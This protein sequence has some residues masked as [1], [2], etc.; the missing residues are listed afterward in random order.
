MHLEHTGFHEIEVIEKVKILVEQALTG[1]VDVLQ[2]AIPATPEWRD[3]LVGGVVDGEMHWHVVYVVITQ[4]KRHQAD[5]IVVQMHDIEIALLDIAGH[6]LAHSRV[7]PEG[8]P[9]VTGVDGAGGGPVQLPVVPEV[10]GSL[11]VVEDVLIDLERKGMAVEGDL[12]THLEP[13]EL[14]CI[15]MRKTRRENFN[16]EFDALLLGSFDQL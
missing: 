16:V 6:G 9:R 12:R 1:Q 11:A 8:H 10:D 14:A 7:E 15:V 5:M 2:G 13:G 3:A 4:I